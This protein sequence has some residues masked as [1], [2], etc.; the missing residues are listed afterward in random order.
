MHAGQWKELLEG[1]PPQA[2]F[3]S[4][5]GAGGDACLLGEVGECDVTA[6]SQALEARPDGAEC[7]VEIV[8]RGAILPLGNTACTPT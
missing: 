8:A 6:E 2:C 5:Q 1:G 4:G 7:V 3:E